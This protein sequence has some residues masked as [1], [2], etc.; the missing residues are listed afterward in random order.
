MAKKLEARESRKARVD[1]LRKDQQRAERRRTILVV[2]ACV[3]VGAVIIG[4]AA[5]PLVKRSRAQSQFNGKAL[6]QIGAAASSAGCQPVATQDA[7]G[8]ADHRQVGTAIT[9]STA[10]P[11]SGPHWAVPAPFSQKF[12]T[13]QDR[14]GV[15]TLVHNLEHGCTILWYDERVAKDAQQVAEVRA[16]ARV[17][18]KDGGGAGKFIAAPWTAEDGDPFPGRAHVAMSHWSAGTGGSAAQAGVLRYCSRVSGEVVGTFVKRY[19]F[20]DSPEPAAG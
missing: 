15:P 16:I 12:Y 9:Y 8:S 19:P 3:V 5:Y 1:Q 20:S 2:A 11:A 13:G 4:F 6:D 18:E 7:T 14:P 17:Y 10:P